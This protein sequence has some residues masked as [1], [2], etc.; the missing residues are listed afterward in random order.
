M[1]SLWI[2]DGHAQFY[3]AYHAIRSGMTSPI[4]NESTHMVFGFVGVL[5][6]LLREQKPERLILVIDAA[7]D[8]GTFR[9]QIDPEYKANRDAPPDDF[10]PQVE[11]CLELCKLLGI[12]VVAVPEVE[13][14]DSIATLVKRVRKAHPEWEIRIAS[15]DKDL[16]Q[17]LDEKT[18]LFDASNGNVLTADAL[19][20]TKGIRPEQ[21][22][23]MLTLM[24]DPTDNVPGAKGIGPKTAVSLITQY[25]SLQGVLDHLDELTPKRRE[26][27]EEA[28]AKFK[29][30]RKLITLKD[31]C[32]VPAGIEEPPLKLNEGNRPQVA[33][34]MRQLGFHRHQTDLDALL[35][36]A[37]VPAPA[38]AAPT[39]PQEK[40]AKK[41]K[42]DDGGPSLF[43]AVGS[44]GETTSQTYAIDP[45]ATRD[46]SY[47]MISNAEELKSFIEEVRRKKKVMLAF[48]TETDSIHPS[49]AGL[50]GVSLSIAPK[51]G[52]YIPLRS[53]QPD[54]HMHWK[55]VLPILKPLLEDASIPKTGHNAKFD[56][57]VLKRHGVELAGLR[58]DTLISSHLLDSSRMSHGMD[59]LAEM[60]L[61][62]RNIAIS[63][64]IGSGKTQRTFDQVP[65]PLATEYAA[66][67]A[68][69]S[70]RLHQLF[71][72]L[73]KA[74]H[75]EKLLEETEL[76]LV[77]VLAC[78]EQNGIHVSAE[79]LDRQRVRLEQRSNS[80]REQVMA[81]SPRPFNLDSP[82]Q[83]A[84][85]LF[86]PA[87]GELPGLGLH[88]VKKT[89]TGA[90]TDV[91]VLERLA[92]D[93]K[94]KTRVPE[95]VLEYR[96]LT[97]LVNTYLVALRDAID[98]ADGRVHASFHQ[99]GTATGRLSSSD[100]N[101]Q[102]IPIRSEDGREIRKAFQAEPGHALV[103]ADYSQIELRILAHMSQDEALMQ[104]FREGKDIHKAVAAETFRVPIEQVNDEQRSAAK[105]VNFGIVYGITPYGLARRLGE[106]SDYEHARGVIE[107]YKK[108][109]R[110][111]ESFLRRCVE[112]AKEHGYV[113][114]MLGRR[115]PIPQVH[116][117]NP[118]ERSLGERM[119]INTVVQGSAAD[120]IKIAM[121]RLHEVL[122]KEFP[123]AK[124]ILQIHDE[125]LV[126]CPKEQAEAVLKRM[127]QVME[128]AMH[129]DIPLQ[130]D[131]GIGGDW[132]DT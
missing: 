57:M 68:D 88:V 125:L 35:G 65:L 91:E 126:E 73:I 59:A 83:L 130:A 31:D 129:L 116:S 75:L 78:M 120:L 115:R 67:D 49:R 51:S 122:K 105:M 97:K 113:Q 10:R 32:A 11:R 50:V 72:P 70:L 43:D 5:L 30:G 118:N 16:G 124:L 25:G 96:Q 9:S 63:S 1:A 80:L 26:A 23:D 108:R 21:V 119:A 38:P 87:Q 15:R 95:L 24:G 89:Q 71:A 131:G 92:N 104:A 36:G 123:K 109:F 84:D 74:M 107:D 111:I 29:L 42:A 27:I 13:A 79:E 66:E 40:P 33:E 69:I 46:G 8:R 39:T 34:L 62:H 22:I 60:L 81:L 52:V 45:L 2:I 54:E 14:D 53:P 64:L 41:K 76:P 58:D 7:G 100:P 56:I 48:D 110:G 93:P 17:I 127:K 90:S 112:Q 103:S 132:F 85:I 86:S 61:G 18:A 55:Q 12:P 98:P 99:A 77:H 6:K 94:V 117:K 114:T 44:G 106:K 47:Q 37:P 19:W 128:G 28:K 102:N 20:E 101:L 121:V 3:R 4:T 82:R